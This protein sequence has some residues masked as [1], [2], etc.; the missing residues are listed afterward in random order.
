MKLLALWDA[1]LS[2]L[3][4]FLPSVNGIPSFHFGQLLVPH[5][6]A[7]AIHFL[8][9]SLSLFFALGS[10]NGKSW[11]HCTLRL[12]RTC[13]LALAFEI[14][15]YNSEISLSAQILLRL[16]HFQN[17][18]ERRSCNFCKSNGKGTSDAPIQ[19]SFLSFFVLTWCFS[20]SVARAKV[21]EDWKEV[22]SLPHPLALECSGRVCRF[23]VSLRLVNFPVGTA[24]CARGI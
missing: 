4:S 1:R 6:V 16:L 2:S 21:M 7:D 19:C 5:Y 3:P 20:T 15:T 13:S 12:P 14:A 18:S 8:G 11:A 24:L 22:S 23:Q 9:L 17:W 10:W